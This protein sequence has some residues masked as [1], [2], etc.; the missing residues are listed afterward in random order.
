M[1]QHLLEVPEVAAAVALQRSG[2]SKEAMAAV[3][4]AVEHFPP[5]IVRAARAEP[6]EAAPAAAAPPA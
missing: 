4:A 6:G 2:R 1:L 3:C 5:D